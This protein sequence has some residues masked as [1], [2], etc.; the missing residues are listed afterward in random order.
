M[1]EQ[2]KALGLL[3]SLIGRPLPPPSLSADDARH[4]R[5]A[6]LDAAR[7]P[8]PS[9]GPADLVELARRLIAA[10][11]VIDAATAPLKPL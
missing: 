7:L 2:E 5:D 6:V 9:T 4:V 8:E 11:R 10:L 3:Q 1:S